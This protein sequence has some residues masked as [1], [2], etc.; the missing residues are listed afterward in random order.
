MSDVRPFAGLRPPPALAVKVAAPPYDVVNTKE[1]RALAE[2]NEQSFFH[3][4]RPE[5]ELPDSQDAHAEAV[6]QLAK[7]NLDKFV[8]SGWLVPDAAP[9]YYVYRQKMGSHTQAGF[10]ACAS[11]DE[12]DKGLIKK[13]ELTRADKEDD[14]TQHIEVLAANDEPVF[15]AYRAQSGLTELQNK[16]MATPPVYDFTSADGVGHTFWVV[17]DAGTIQA[18]QKGFER[19]EALYVADGH[20]RSAAASRVAKLGRSR[21]GDE[22]GYFLVVVFPHDQLQILDYNRVVKDLAGN[23]PEAFLKKI[24]QRF[25][26]TPGR[27]KANPAAQ[28]RD[29]PGREVAHAHRQGGHVRIPE[30]HRV[31]RRE[32]P[33]RR[34]AR[35]DPGHQ[36]PA[37]G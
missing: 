27:R 23:T 29:V 14:R 28:L 35:A 10:V 3:V 19:V 32:H 11:V 13:H 16:V 24:R 36:G 8:S 37:E 1:A 12:Y 33:A 7:K 2:S 25:E 20:H 15:L 5:I 9:R 26:V 31:A 22:R 34:S 30:P 6:Y 18:I 21:T 17:S 4:S